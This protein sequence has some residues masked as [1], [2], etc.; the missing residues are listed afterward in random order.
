M[1]CQWF[2]FEK[3]ILSTSPSRLFAYLNRISVESV[4]TGYISSRLEQSIIR[5]NFK[6]SQIS[7]SY[8]LYK[9]LHVQIKMSVLSRRRLLLSGYSV[10]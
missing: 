5:D 8:N 2:E 3:D 10:V 9:N 1:S 6:G 7:K 4:W